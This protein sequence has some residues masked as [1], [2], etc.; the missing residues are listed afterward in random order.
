MNDLS[1]PS[2]ANCGS[3]LPSYA[4]SFC[5]DCGASLLE[6]RSMIKERFVSAISTVA[7]TEPYSNLL[8][9]IPHNSE[10]L[11]GAIRNLGN[12]LDSNV[13]KVPIA[14]ASVFKDRK[15]TAVA[16]GLVRKSPEIAQV[17]I[18]FTPLAP[19]SPLIASILE[20]ATKQNNDGATIKTQ[21]PA[22]F[23]SEC[24][25]KLRPDSKFCSNCGTKQT[26]D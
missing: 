17:I 24:G 8:A 19:Y 16:K 10:G 18:G 25:N 5:P 22:K 2:C 4:F 12:S 6:R 3:I 11:S 9:K 7:D 1:V 20:R 13:S 23:C 21:L 14:S 15:V 26:G